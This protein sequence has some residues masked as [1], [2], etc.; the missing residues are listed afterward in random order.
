MN[1]PMVGLLVFGCTFGAGLVAMMTRRQLPSNHV[2]GPLADLVKLVLGLIATLTALVLSLLISS[3]YSA[4]QAQQAELQQLSVHLYQ[5]DRALAHFGP[6]ANPQRD[7]LRRLLAANIARIW[8]ADGQAPTRATTLQQDAEA[9][10]D[11]VEA[12]G[13]KTD[14]Q[15]LGRSKALE[16][17]ESSGETWHLLA[18]PS[19][20]TL[21]RPILVVLLMW[22]TILFFGFGLFAHF[23][24]TAGVSLFMGS[25]S[26]AGAVFLIVDMSQP[27]SGWVKISAAPL[28]AALAQMGH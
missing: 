7:A 22:V 6:E 27:Y 5:L 18:A 23:N 28:R 24:L 1:S 16:L 19:E 25:L 3:G 20:A 17:L 15:R 10:F 13:P 26:V 11:G 12:L 9:L 21:S 8:P 4:Y 2:E 14:R